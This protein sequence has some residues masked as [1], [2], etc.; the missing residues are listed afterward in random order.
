MLSLRSI[1]HHHRAL[2]GG[3]IAVALVE[4]SLC[5]H[6]FNRTEP[7]ANDGFHLDVWK[8]GK[9]LGI[10]RHPGPAAMQF[11]PVLLLLDFRLY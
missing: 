1:N 7:I 8:I 2:G 3:P 6:R 4:E 9:D 5:T 10:A 11:G